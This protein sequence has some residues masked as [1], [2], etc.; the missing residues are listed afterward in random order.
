LWVLTIA[1]DIDEEIERWRPLVQWLLCIPHL[2]YN[3]VATGVSLLAWLV[4]VPVVLVTGRVPKRLAELQVAV[5]RERART[6]G[7]LFVLRRSAPPFATTLSSIDPGDDPS[8]T[9][10]VHIADRAPR[11]APAMRLFVVLPHVL[12][13]LPIGVCLDALYPMWMVLVAINRGW[14]AGMARTLASIE[15]WVVEVILYV[16]MASD[17]PPRFGLSLEREAAAI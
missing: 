9:L 10:S 15:R 1:L 13:L 6:F 4:T 14:P 11:W 7:Y 5:L 12:V 2:V 17:R 16:T 8:L 3:A